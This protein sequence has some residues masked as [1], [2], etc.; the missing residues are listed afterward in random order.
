M[1]KA[2]IDTNVLLD[3]LLDREGCKEAGA[4]LLCQKEGKCS[5]WLSSLSIANIAYILRKKFRGAE[6]YDALNRL[7]GFFHIADLS[8]SNVEAALAL[9]AS[10][11][12]DA[13]QYFSARDVQADVIVT[14]NEKDF[15]FS[16]IKIMSPKD[17]LKTVLMI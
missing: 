3:L 15:Y 16:S 2:F 13:M 12:E 4:I 1:I 7:K 8:A 5:L 11:F 17:F 14:R 10:D 6:L 9:Q